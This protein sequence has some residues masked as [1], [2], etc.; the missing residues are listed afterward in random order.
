LFNSHIAEQRLLKAYGVEM[1]E[2]NPTQ[3][4][5]YPIGLFFIQLPLQQENGA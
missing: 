5:P 2:R 4:Y 3:F 1:W